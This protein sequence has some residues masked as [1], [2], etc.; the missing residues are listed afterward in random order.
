MTKQITIDTFPGLIEILPEVNKT[1]DSFNEEI[2]A[3]YG[4]FGIEYRYEDI[5]WTTGD[6]SGGTNGLGGT[7]ARAGYTAGNGTDA[8]EIAASGSQIDMLNLIN[9]SNV[10]EAGIYRWDVR[11]GIVTAPEVP[12]PAALFMFAPALLGFFGLRRKAKVQA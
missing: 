2:V 9:T 12:V 5:N 1:F 4:D 10:G 7:V 11:G 6:A 3:K 8:F